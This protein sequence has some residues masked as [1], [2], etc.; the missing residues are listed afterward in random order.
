MP[1]ALPA[2]P[3]TRSACLAL[4]LLPIA[5]S[6]MAL[7]GA[8]D[9]AFGDDGQVAI[10]RPRDEGFGNMTK[11]TGDL[12]MLAD[13]RFT[14]VQ[15]LDDGRVWMGRQQRNG[16]ADAFGNGGDGR[17]TLPACGGTAPARLVVEP[18]GSA[19]VWASSCFVR[20]HADGSIDTAFARGAQPPPGF[21]ATAL[22]RDASG[23]YVLAGDEGLRRVVYRFEPGGDPDAGFG[24]GGR[25]ELVIPS[26]NGIVAIHALAVRADG[27]IV[28][29][30]SRGNTH[31]PNLA[32][33]QLTAAGTPDPQWSGDGL[34]D[35]APP[36]GYDRLYA[37]AIALDV[38]DSLVVSGMG[39]DGGVGCCRLLARF[40]ANGELVPGFGLRLFRLGGQPSLYPFFEQRDGLVLRSNR[41]ILVGAISF[42]F[43]APFGHRTRYTLIRTHVDGRLDEH[44]GQQGWTSY[45]IADP[46]PAGQ[47]GD[48]NQM[49]AIAHDRGD[50][51]VVV[52]GRT[53]F[54]DESTFDDYVTMVRARLDL[55]FDDAFEP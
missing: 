23:R 45:T 9:P 21:R 31:G 43:T 12:A 19:V 46:T 16:A 35:I 28:V 18:D 47:S 38:D 49:H 5:T 25:A 29:A 2:T 24:V 30:G 1:Q 4:A 26:S 33:A 13:G 48:Y 39:G 54:E 20:V 41:R 8:P 15:P 55:V 17:I 32:I 10:T 3:I 44:F 37:T 34:V 36:P 7:D 53:F 50:D 6:A 40:D 42:P 52:F 11:P 27:R 51:S 14:W 22:V